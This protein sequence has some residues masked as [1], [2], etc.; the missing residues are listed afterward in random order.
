MIKKIKYINGIRFYRSIVV[1][2]NNLISRQDYLNQINVFPVPDGDTGTNMAFTVNEILEGTSGTVS[3]KI[4][5]MSQEV[6]D[7]ALDGARGN[8]GAILAQFFV[9]LS[10]GLEGKDTMSVKDF[11][12]AFS[13]ASDNAWE[14]LSNPQEGTILTIFKDLSKFLL[15]HTSNP[16]N[17]DF[18]PLMDLCL[19]E[20]QKSLNNTPMQ[21]QL[22]KKAGVVDAG[23]QGFVDLLKGINDFIQSGRIKDLGHIINT[24][25]EFEDFEN[26]HDY[27]NLTYQFCTECVIEGDSIDKKEIKS[28]LMEIG[29][30][31]VIAGS[32]KKV[33]VHIHVN[34]PHQLFQVCNKYGITKNHKADDMFK[35]QK[36]VK[37]GKTNKIALVVDSGADFNIEKYFDVFVVPVRYSF[38]NQD[39]IDKVSQ[40]IEDFYTELKNNPDHPK[41]SQP[42]P[43]DFRRQYQY[44]NSYYS[45][46]ISLH[47]PKKLS[48]T[49]QSA[50]VAARNTSGANISV[51]DGN[52]M[53]VGMGLCVEKAAEIINNEKLSHD[54]I[55]SKINTIIDDTTVFTA[56]RDLSYAVKGGRVPSAIK[57]I[58]NILNFKPVL[59]ITKEGLMKPVSFYFGKDNIAEKLFKIV[60]KKIDLSFKYDVAIGH[61][62][63][64]EDSK[65]I[66]L[67]FEKKSDVFKNIRILKI[68]GA[69]GVHTGPGALSVSVQKIND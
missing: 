33:K 69:L 12:N 50:C 7:L 38:G 41:T 51:I 15:E 8:S 18:V 2:I 49:Y 4:G 55:V 32:K 68:G 25:K 63:A 14:A 56:V 64:K 30:S 19:V 43:G 23:A 3:S 66:K 47:I 24:P 36:L 67:L 54:E 9:G 39:Y 58:S 42:T 59:S 57:T 48:G 10:E 16:N 62:Q 52:N 65:K 44:L 1:G 27:S 53:S 20:A 37:T 60:N 31:V 17:D 22:L 11:A 13:K 21:M 29:D 34:K 6:A 40:S 5:E 28:R 46:I 61:A 35:Q 45:S 26:E